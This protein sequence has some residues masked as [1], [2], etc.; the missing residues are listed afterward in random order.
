[1]GSDDLGGT[2]FTAEEFA[3]GEERRQRERSDATDAG[4]KSKGNGSTE[5]PVLVPLAAPQAAERSYPVKALPEIL[6]DAVV[7]Y[8][9]Y[10]Q[11]PYPLVATSAFSCMSLAAQGLADIARDEYL[12]GPISLYFL[13][14]AVSGERKTSSDNWFKAPLLRWMVELRDA[15]QDEVAEANAAIAAWQ[16]MRDGLIAKIKSASGKPPKP[17]SDALSVEELQSDLADLEKAKPAPVIV[18][19]LFYEDTN[20]PTLASD[21]AQDWPSASLWSDEA[22]LVVGAHGMNDDMAMG[23]FG[24]LNRLWDGKPFDRDRS[25]ARRA[26]MRGR[27]FTV[28][29]MAQP[30]VMARLLSVA[31]EASRGMG[32]LSR[33]FLAWPTSTIGTR[34]YR[35]VEHMPAIEKFTARIR[36]LLDMPLPLDPEAPTIMA[37]RPPVLKLT[38]EA[39][40]KWREFH[41]DVEAEIGKTGEYAAVADVGA[42]IAENAARLAANFHILEHGPAGEIDVETMLGAIKIVNWHFYEARRVLASFNT[43]QVVTDA[44]ILLEW[45]LSWPLKDDL[46]DPRRILQF[47]PRALGRDVKRRD[48]AINLLVEH[49]FL[50]KLQGRARRYKLNRDIQ[51][52]SSW[53]HE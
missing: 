33:F 42:K 52:Q 10:G 35:E 19:R 40:Q 24:L 6:Q 21:F 30:I 11:Q 51:T 34:A 2:F 13:A 15:R 29:L 39:A 46:V 22:G 16:A 37:L 17:D 43:S 44:E 5:W 9:E 7:E 3:R 45:L 27:R 41:D 31:S 49:G 28:S 23:F 26:Y 14:I 25:S 32:L 47:G 48:A 50:T 1:M 53:G 20:S 12:I 36:E 4:S 8:R 18:P 38:V